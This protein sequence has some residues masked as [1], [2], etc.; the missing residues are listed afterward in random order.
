MYSVVGMYVGIDGNGNG[1]GMT[2]P[3]TGRVSRPSGAQLYTYIGTYLRYSLDLTN[4]T[5]LGI[6]KL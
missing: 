3:I 2:V 4:P 5:N 1:N 6:N